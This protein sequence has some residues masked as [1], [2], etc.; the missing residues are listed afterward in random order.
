MSQPLAGT[1]ALVTGASSG[2]GAATAGPLAARGCGRRP[3]GAARRPA[4]GAGGRPLARGRGDRAWC[5][6]PT[7]PNGSRRRTGAV[8][9][10]VAE[11]Q[12]RLDTVVNN[13]GVMLTGPRAGA[14]DG[15]WDRMIAVNVQALL[16]VTQAALPHL[17]AAAGSRLAGS[18]T[19]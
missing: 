7:S 18:P 16:H 4:R 11:K 2:I 8:E 17:V 10:A 13:A 3:A 1:A 15:E 9:L 19:W 12:R 14:G 5:W 6:M